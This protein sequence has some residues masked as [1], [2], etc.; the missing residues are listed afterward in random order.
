[1]RLPDEKT[2]EGVDAVD[3]YA[4]LRWKCVLLGSEVVLVSYDVPLGLSALLDY[5]ALDWVSDFALLI[6]TPAGS[7]TAESRTLW[8]NPVRV[9]YIC[10]CRGRARRRAIPSQ[11]TTS[12]SW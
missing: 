4:A 9:Q 12:R 2:C 1:M 3:S 8:N 10:T 6:T 7:F 5:E 11:P